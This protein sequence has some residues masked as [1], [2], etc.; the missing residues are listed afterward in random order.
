M[1]VGT[2]RAAKVLPRTTLR[3]YMMFCGAILLAVSCLHV[4]FIGIPVHLLALPDDH[5]P[6]SELVGAVND[7]RLHVFISYNLSNYLNEQPK[8]GVQPAA[9]TLHLSGRLH[10][11]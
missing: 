8:H 10:E 6:G 5:G 9:L 11:V 3:S 7:V 4:V 2:T 1:E